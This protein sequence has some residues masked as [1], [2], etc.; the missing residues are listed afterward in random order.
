MKQS[1]TTYMNMH[2]N[3]DLKDHKPEK[4]ED[5]SKYDEYNDLLDKALDLSETLM[6][7]EKAER[8]EDLVIS[9]DGKNIIRIP[10]RKILAEWDKMMD[11]QDLPLWKAPR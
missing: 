11:K 3:K 1:T 6:L 8:N 9:T 10:A 5:F 7:R 2:D 4:I